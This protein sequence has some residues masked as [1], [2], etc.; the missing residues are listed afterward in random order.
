MGLLKLLELARTGVDSGCEVVRMLSGA[1]RCSASWARA[2]EVLPEELRE[3]SVKFPE[4]RADLGRSMASPM[5]RLGECTRSP[6]SAGWSLRIGPLSSIA[7][8]RD[9]SGRLWLGKPPF[10]SCTTSA[11]AGSGCRTGAESVSVGLGQAAWSGS[12]VDGIVALSARTY[13]ERIQ[14][15]S[16]YL[17]KKI[18]KGLTCRFGSH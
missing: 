7:G 1:A 10:L 12:G 17:N 14:D 2:N 6:R 8:S 16:Q 4:C 5:S 3:S 11:G 9:C 18:E 13:V 15:R